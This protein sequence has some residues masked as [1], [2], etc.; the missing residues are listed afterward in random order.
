MGCGILQKKNHRFMTYRNG[1]T[2][3]QNGLV[4]NWVELVLSSI[5]S[6]EKEMEL[7]D[8]ANVNIETLVAQELPS[9]KVE[10]EF[11]VGIYNVISEL[12][13]TKKE[14]GMTYKELSD[15]T[16]T[17][18]DNFKKKG[19]PINPVVSFAVFRD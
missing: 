2:S 10:R 5:A 9:S 15:Y 7:S 16:S 17:M 4:S 1:M 3:K 18:F 13:K 6:L 14:T 19:V 8:Q 11:Q 12:E